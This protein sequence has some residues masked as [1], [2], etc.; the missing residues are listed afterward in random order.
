[1]AD[2]AMRLGTGQNLVVGHPLAQGGQGSVHEVVSPPGLVFKRYSDAVLASQPSPERRIQAMIDN[3]PSQWREKSGHLL[4]AWPTAT[5]LD[6]RRFVGFVMP[7][8][9]TSRAAELHLVS[10]PS[11]RAKPAKNV[12]W[13]AGFTWRYLVQTAANLSLATQGLHDAGY[14]IGDFNERNVLVHAD[15][16]VT[17]VDCDSMQVRDP[18]TKTLYLCEVGRE[19]FEAPERHGAPRTRPRDESADLFPLAV[20]IFQLLF[21]GRSP[22]DGVWSGPGEKPSR[23]ALAQRGMFNCSGDR[24]LRPQ[25]TAPPF[26][27]VPP[28]L[29]RLFT[30]AFVDGAKRPSARPMAGEWQ[31]ALTT[32]ARGLR[33]CATNTS[34]VYGGHLGRCPWCQRPA[35]PVTMATQIRPPPAA[36]PAR[37]ATQPTRTHRPAPQPSPT[38]PTGRRPVMAVNTR[39]GLTGPTPTPPW[40]RP[41][42]PAPS[43]AARPRPARRWRALKKAL[44]RLLALLGIALAA[45][46]VALAATGV[47]KDMNNP[48]G[49]FRTA[50]LGP[51]GY[52]YVSRT[53]HGA[54]TV[55]RVEKDGATAKI[56][57]NGKKTGGD[58]GPATRAG[59]R[60]VT[61]LAFDSTGNAYLNEG[62]DIR[63]VDIRG[64][65]TTVVGGGTD[66]PADGARATG[67]AVGGLR[68]AVAPDGTLHFADD[69]KVWK[70]QGDGT[71]ATVAGGG[72][73]GGGTSPSRQDGIPA[74][75]SYLD[76]DAI[77]F[78]KTGLLLISD[79]M[80]RPSQ[81]DSRLRQVGLDGTI[82][83]VAGTLD[84]Q[85]P[86]ENENGI[87]TSALVR[88]HPVDQIGLDA[89][90]LVVVGSSGRFIRLNPDGSRTYL[91]TSGGTRELIPVSG[92][93][94]AVRPGAVDL[95]D[96]R[97]VT[98]SKVCGKKACQPRSW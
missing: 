83:T 76:V 48:A 24:R 70:L 3:R 67:I 4:L 28:D 45:G 49:E 2:D 43:T 46:C 12:A 29:R 97:G 53:S 87:G 72:S 63:K 5:V 95:D 11:D 33:T 1:M 34:H 19:E 35:P 68:M 61:D 31:T 84:E 42:T 54:A 6:G 8:I 15:A 71:I 62:T 82:Q 37:T 91:L 22:F 64:V 93:F 96:S 56:A 52:L 98:R 40:T 10:N 81:Y 30:R 85:R 77:A 14:V 75:E 44:M 94:L 88:F 57:G 86:F 65:I 58:G 25:P 73:T 80:A 17:L 92:G 38:P 18:R 66:A 60:D 9:D 51:F 21:E 47:I 59:L 89:D 26:D 39:P 74:T 90:G 50:A 16:R 79:V 27:L 69:R 13:T 20:H 23:G 78:D 32:L 36:P 55:Y 7:R 41:F